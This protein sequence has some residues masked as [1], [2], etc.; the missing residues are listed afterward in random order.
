M[1]SDDYRFQIDECD[2]DLAN[3]GALHTFRQKRTHWLSW[4]KTD[5]HHPI[6]NE[7]SSIAWNDVAFRVLGLAS[8]IDPDGALGNQLIFQAAIQGHFATQSLSIRRLMDQ[9]K[10]VISLARLVDDIDKHIGLFTRENCIAH[11]GLPYDWQAAERKVIER[12]L[13]RSSGPFWGAK[14]GPDAWA[15]SKSAHEVFDQLSGVDPSRRDRN[16]R[17]P[18]AI[19]RTLRDWLCASG[20]GQLIVWS[21]S[22]LAHAAVDGPRRQSIDLSTAAPTLDKITAALRCFVRVSE[23]VSAYL[24]LAGGHGMI[25]PVA[26]FDKFAGL[27]PVLTAPENRTKLNRQWDRLAKERND[28]LQGTLESLATH[29]PR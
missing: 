16:D 23:A 3:R 1:A 29:S 27:G 21:N 24:L 7:I 11:D 19:I 14:W 6:D 28:F 5:Q 25:V 4:L 18:R 10:D 2:V 9:A 15:V 26:Q 22:F 12:E 17:I 8:E 13:A 20:T